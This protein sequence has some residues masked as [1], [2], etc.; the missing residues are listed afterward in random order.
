MATRLSVQSN[1]G[2]EPQDAEHSGSDNLK[3][4]AWLALFAG[5]FLFWVL[6]VTMVW[7][8]WN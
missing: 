1:F 8:L 6:V 2:H 5:S 3:R 7:N 4:N